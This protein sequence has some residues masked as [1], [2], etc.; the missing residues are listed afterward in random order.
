MNEQTNES[1]LPALETLSGL[2]IT[3]PIIGRISIGGVD[4]DFVPYMDNEIHITSLI[5][6]PDYSWIEHP[7]HETVRTNS[8]LDA[9]KKLQSIPV[10]LMYN[11]PN[12]NFSSRFVAFEA[13]GGRVLCHGNNGKAYRNENGCIEEYTC[14]GSEHCDFGLKSGCKPHGRLFVQVDGQEDYLG[15]F[16]HRTSGLNTTRYLSSRLIQMSNM[17]RGKIAGFPLSLVMRM[18]TSHLTG[19]NIVFLDLEF[20]R[21]MSIKDL[22]AAQVE[23]LTDWADMGW[24]RHSFEQGVRTALTTN[25][26]SEIDQD[27]GVAILAEFYNKN[28]SGGQQKGKEDKSSGGKRAAAPISNSLAD[29]ASKI[30]LEAE[31]EAAKPSQ[32]V[33]DDLVQ[34]ETLELT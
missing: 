34:E 31:A 4:S 7:V 5:Q 30:K 6:N 8:K 19:A 28:S 12:L 14:P 16:V 10:R 33:S 20:R 9:N 17:M 32:S 13:T 29:L 21:G 27:D 23:Y 18:K 1:I 11:D 25:G 3:P 26:V 24:D 22:K 2:S 15:L